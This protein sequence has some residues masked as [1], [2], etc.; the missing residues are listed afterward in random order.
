MTAS[1]V[2]IFAFGAFVTLLLF[3][4]LFF[5]IREF[6]EINKHPERY[7]NEPDFNFGGKRQRTDKTEM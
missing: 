4:G 1:D 3:G 5:T 6:R 2:I 7:V